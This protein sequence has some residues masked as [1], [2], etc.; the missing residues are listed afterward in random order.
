MYRYTTPMGPPLWVD[1]EREG[2]EAVKEEGLQFLS[3]PGSGA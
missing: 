3:T 1:G 2:P